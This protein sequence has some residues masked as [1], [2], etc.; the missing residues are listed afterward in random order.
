[1]SMVST[2]ISSSHITFTVFGEKV[3]EKSSLPSLRISRT[4]KTNRIR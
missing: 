3:E 1:M 4:V 2:E